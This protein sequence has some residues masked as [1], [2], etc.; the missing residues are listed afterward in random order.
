MIGRKGKKPSTQRNPHLER[1]KQATFHY[2]SNR[3][4]VER[5]HERISADAPQAN[6]PSRIAQMQKR[7]LRLPYLASG[8][9]V[10]LLCLYM[11]SLNTNPRVVITNGQP[12]RETASYNQA[13]NDAI[14]DGLLSYSKL[15]LNRQNLV[16]NLQSTFPEMQK[17]NVATPLWSRTPVIKAEISPP[18]M[19]LTTDSGDFPLN[20]AGIALLNTK[21]TPL[22]IGT[23]DLL[24]VQD[25][26]QAP[27]QVGKP[28]LTSSQ[29]AFI[30]EVKRQSDAKNMT[31]ESVELTAGGGELILR[32]EG[33]P[34]I[35]K[36]S[37]YEDARKSF[38]TFY[39][40]REQ[41]EKSKLKPLEYIDVRIAERA[42]IK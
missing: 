26:S 24:I 19:V 13:A 32:Y 21:N 41:A 3:S 18:L 16:E 39:A 14:P 12:V 10:L 38:G 2:S 1:V 4:Q 33:L 31:V 5:E 7:L 6:S 20:R 30:T 17:V 29:V 25:K 34:Y 22:T 23:D 8:A 9:A 15:T 37:M 28:A 40:A 42:Y 11:S 36:Y 27:I 35:V